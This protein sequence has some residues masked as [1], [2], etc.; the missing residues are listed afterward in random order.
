MCGGQGFDLNFA[1]I[2]L[3]ALREGSSYIQFEMKL[4]DMHL[5]GLDIG[6]MNQSREFMRKFVASMANVMD[7]KIGSH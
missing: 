4:R 5:A 1:R 7:R 2:V 6:S 3:Q